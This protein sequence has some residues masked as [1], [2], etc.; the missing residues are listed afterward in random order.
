MVNIKAIIC[1]KNI[2]SFVFLY[3]IDI[4][5]Y[6]RLTILCY[7]ENMIALVSNIKLMHLV[8]SYLFKYLFI[9]FILCNDLSYNVFRNTIIYVY[10]LVCILNKIFFDILFYYKCI[11]MEQLSVTFIHCT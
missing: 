6:I 4:I 10:A 7:T 3:T 5:C 9:Y 2:K 11:L 8:F 1:I